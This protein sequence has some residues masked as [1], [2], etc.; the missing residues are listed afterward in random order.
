MVNT[1]DP[2]KAP[3]L[4]WGQRLALQGDGAGESWTAAGGPREVHPLVIRPDSS[5]GHSSTPMAFPSTAPGAS[6]WPRRTPG[7]GRFR[8]PW[9]TGKY[10]DPQSYFYNGH[11]NSDNGAD[12]D[13][14]TLPVAYNAAQDTRA[15]EQAMRQAV[16][17]AYD[18]L[19]QGKATDF[20]HAL[21]Y[22]LANMASDWQRAQ[23]QGQRYGLGYDPTRFASVGY[24]DAYDPNKRYLTGVGSAAPPSAGLNDGAAAAAQQGATPPATQPGTSPKEDTV[25]DSPLNSN[26]QPGQASGAPPGAANA[27]VADSGAYNSFLA[28]NPAAR[29]QR[30][31]QLLGIGNPTNARSIFGSHLAGLADMFD[32]WSLTQDLGGT[33]Q[34]DDYEGMLGRFVGKLKAPGSFGQFAS[35]ATNAMNTIDWSKL[36]DTGQGGAPAVIAKLQGLQTYGMNPLMGTVYGNALDDALAMFLNQVTETAR[37]DPEKAAAMRFIQHLQNT[38]E[39]KRMLGL[40]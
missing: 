39:I 11:N 30:L 7:G 24:G 25:A 37:A 32:P 36:G 38:P 20:N 35:D 13:W 3:R 23:Q 8:A 19:E 28:G 29:T 34:V 17:R 18:M 21:S 14:V 5:V 12:G 6:I 40:R 16:R 4:T 22:W 26:A 1:F 9:A 15:G 10:G 31:Y 33:Q 27:Q 2:W